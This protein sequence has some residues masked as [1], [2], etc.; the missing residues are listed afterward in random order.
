MKDSSF[1]KLNFIDQ[2]DYNKRMTICEYC[3]GIEECNK[4]G[5]YGMKPVIMYRES[6]NEYTLASQLCGKQPGSLSGSYAKLIKNPVKIYDNE[7]RRS[8][9]RE[10]SKCKGG[11]L[12][13]ETGVG[14]S[15]IMSNLAKQFNDDGKNVHYEFAN[16]ISVSLR[17]FDDIED[18][19][20]LLQEVEILFI[21]DLA[22]EVM[23][24]WVIMNIFNPI[25]QY[26]IDNGMVTY[27]TCNYSLEELY[28][29]IKKETDTVSADA[30]CDRISTIGTYNLQDRNHRI[31]SNIIEDL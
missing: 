24:K 4:N 7:E 6:V 2:T 10:L 19:M 28:D 22:R 13:G 26:R 21:D 20:K 18:K 29:M 16:R 17:N 12:Y 1:D 5:N 14:K 31:D 15:T 9:V 27:I 23:T 25:L 3:R 11:F 30:M 8:I